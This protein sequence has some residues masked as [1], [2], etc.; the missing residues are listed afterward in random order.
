M[1][2]LPKSYKEEKLSAKTNSLIRSEWGRPLTKH[3]FLRA[4][5]S[6]KSL[7][8]PAQLSQAC[9]FSPLL[10]LQITSHPWEN[11]DLRCSSLAHVSSNAHSRGHPPFRSLP[12]AAVW[13]C[14]ALVIKYVFKTCGGVGRDRNRHARC[15]PQKANH[16]SVEFPAMFSGSPATY[17]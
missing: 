10:H 4:Q 13:L 12:S 7:C 16:C 1:S 5:D 2:V 6:G 15:I 8:S 11:E 9:S 14:E 17:S 3:Y